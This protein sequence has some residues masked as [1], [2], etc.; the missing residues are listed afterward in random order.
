[1][2]TPTYP[3]KP[4]RF[5]LPLLL[6]LAT[7]PAS[8][9]TEPNDDQVFELSAFEVAVEEDRG[10]FSPNSV[11]ATG[12]SQEIFKTPLNIAALT[13]EF[14]TDVGSQSL[15]DAMGYI[16]GVTLETNLTVPNQRFRARGFVTQW[17]SR[18]GINFYGSLGV[19]NIDRIEVVRGPSSVFF[20]QVSPGGVV[21]FTTK[22]ASFNKKTDVKLQYGSYDHYYAN[23]GTQGPLWEDGPVA[24]RFYA[25]YLDKKDWRDFE[26]EERYFIYGGLQWR[27]NPRLK[28]FLE[29]EQTE[30]DYMYAHGLPRGNKVWVETM[31]DLPE[32]M[33][34][35]ALTDPRYDPNRWEPEEFAQLLFNSNFPKFKE[36][37]E[38]IF[39]GDIGGQISD[40]VPQ[41]TPRGRKFNQSGPYGWRYFI[42]EIFTAEMN[43]NPVDWLSIRAI[44][45]DNYSFR[46]GFTATAAY[47]EI[48]SADGSFRT[49]LPTQQMH[50]NNSAHSAVEAVL[51]FDAI[52]GSHRILLGGSYYDDQY[53]TERFLDAPSR[54]DWNDTSWNVARS[55]Y[56]DR[57]TRDWVIVEDAPLGYWNIRDYIQ[58]DEGHFPTGEGVDI[59]TRAY[60]TSYV[61]K[62]LEDRL[63]LM[64]GIRDETYV[65]RQLVD[66]ERSEE[67]GA[68][69]SYE[70]KTPMAGIVY[71]FKDG[72]S[73]FASYSLG[74]LPGTGR[75][76]QGNQ[77][78]VDELN[79]TGGNKEGEGIELGFKARTEDNRLSGTLSLFQISFTNDIRTKDW[80]R[81]DADPRNQ[82]DDPFDDVVWFTV[83]GDSQTQGM[84]VD[85]IY[86]PIPEL[87]MVASWSYI[88]Q[89]E[90][91]ENLSQPE[92]QGSRFAN[93]PKHSG[94]LWTKYSFREKWEG[95]SIGFGVKYNGWVWQKIQPDRSTIQGDAYFV[96]D[97]LI[98]YR[99]QI[100]DIN[101]RFA[102]N[103]TNLFDK[104]YLASAFGAQSAA[105]PGAVRK[106]MFTVDLTF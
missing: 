90:V 47:T 3:L 88:W 41:A 61:G 40:A 45:V 67:E 48:I 87:Q 62:F 19:E 104:E 27:V 33:I 24:Y 96:C 43:W 50:K 83:G 26:F 82:N 80:A 10:Y 85:F 51:E 39:G 78:T 11:V 101:T 14:L 6:I 17:T 37:Y 91:L 52:G 86:T 13:E 93:T 76:I 1:M 58:F 7:I 12:F 18:N 25:S 56:I 77:L 81:T 36:D 31:K 44:H 102:L 106:V 94:S 9:Q 64:A 46:P 15:E 4:N 57:S 60:Y 30:A 2:K 29:Y 21:N 38:S 89:A 65:R 95:L 5:L 79:L 49:S 35:L 8:G 73:A 66:F 42:N 28:F 34:D 103:V 23:F 54:P 59:F 97:A 16:G 22:R 68:R 75:L 55:G 32:E 20:G 84:E 53:S 105:V 69:A 92:Q 74:Y 71:E 99:T 100:R 98:E 72:I 63:V 70:E